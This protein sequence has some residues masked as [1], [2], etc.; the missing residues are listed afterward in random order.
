MRKKD[1]TLIEL[2]VVIAIIAILAGMLLPALNKAKLT[3]QK[4]SCANNFVSSG[5]MLTFYSDDNKEIYPVCATSTFRTYNEFPCVM[6]GYWPKEGYGVI[7]CAYGSKSK[8][9]PSSKYVC[10]SAIPSAAA[11]PTYW[12]STGYFH[13]QGYNFF[14]SDTRSGP[15]QTTYPT[16]LRRKNRWRFPSRLMIM[17]D[18]SD[19]GINF[20]TTSSEGGEG[21]RIRPW[22]NG[23]CNVLFADGHLDWL[24]TSVIPDNKRWPGCRLKA[25]FYPVSE[26]SDWY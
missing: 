9:K 23:G 6:F 8:N 10:P 16:Y 5:K 11:D 20:V 18:A 24:R 12:E 7:Y 14:F 1:F 17:G 26:T 25:F 3:A 13:T 19:I 2:L 15:K 22:H 4:I 21:Q